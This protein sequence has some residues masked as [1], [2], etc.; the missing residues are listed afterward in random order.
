M[1]IDRSH[2]LENTR[3]VRLRTALGE[4]RNAY[5]ALVRADEDDIAVSCNW[6]IEE[7]EIK[8]AE[9]EQAMLERERAL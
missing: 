9:S 2:D 1:N 5:G 8:L 7:V 4:L 6:L 3:R